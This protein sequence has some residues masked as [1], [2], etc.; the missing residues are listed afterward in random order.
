VFPLIDVKVEFFVDGEKEIAVGDFITYKITVTSLNLGD[1]D[2]PGFIH[3][4]AFPFL[5]QSNWALMFTDLE[6][7]NFFKMEKVLLREKVSVFT[8]KQRVMQA[9]TV[10]FKVIFKNDSYKGF[11]KQMNVEFAVLKEAVRATPEYDEED[12]LATKAPSMMQAMME[13]NQDN[14]DDDESDGEEEKKEAVV[15]S[16]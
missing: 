14:S 9:G 12:I 2:R 16:P 8:E 10:R 15:G 5:K 4:N 11:D 1:T 6:E 13:M 7:V 3:S